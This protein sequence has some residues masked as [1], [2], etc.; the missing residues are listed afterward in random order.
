MAV[1]LNVRMEMPGKEPKEYAYDFDQEIITLGRDSNNDIQ[2]P[3]TTVSRNHAKIVLEGGEYFLQ[4]LNSTHGTT[5]NG[6]P[7]GQGGKK[8]LRS[9]D[10]IELMHFR[11]QFVA[12][13]DK[14]L[15]MGQSERTEMLA[16]RMVQ[17]VLSSIGGG[18][19][20][21]YLRVM[22]GPDE[23]K[24][25]ELGD[26]VGEV[27]IG[28]ATECDFCINDANISRRHALVRKDWSG[29]TVED[30]GS[31]N[32]V[33][34]NEKKIEKAAPLKDSDEIS[35]GAVK[36]VFIDPTASM[37]GKLDDIPVFQTGPQEQPAE[38]EAA[39]GGEEAAEAPAEHSGE[40]PAEGGEHGGEAV[41]EGGEAAAAGEGEAEGE[42]KPEDA[43]P[44]TGKSAADY[45][46]YGAVGLV[47]LGLVA[48]GI[49]VAI[50]M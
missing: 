33:C 3:L 16:R 32:G 21:P 5:H 12:E 42:G 39:E 43:A 18:T 23:G 34:I 26:G 37:L 14:P 2:I 13:A 22:N 24:R 15:E 49:V 19:E 8:L 38:G 30:L 28:R 25:F 11:I 17:E 45:V 20:A 40:V 36:L 44:T 48:L 47:V 4:D 41:A 9:G 35:L 46:V 29:I 27:V 50:Q 31:K 6:K 1:K 10:T 7:V